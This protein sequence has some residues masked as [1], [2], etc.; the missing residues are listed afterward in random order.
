MTSSMTS[1]ALILLTALTAAAAAQRAGNARR[2]S[3]QEAGTSSPPTATSC[4]ATR[5]C[6]V[7]AGR[8]R[9][10]SVQVRPVPDADGLVELTIGRPDNGPVAWKV[11]F[12]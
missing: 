11:V 12:G 9:E 10:L 5:M 6:W 1:K 3:V 2:M 4:R 8:K 7:A